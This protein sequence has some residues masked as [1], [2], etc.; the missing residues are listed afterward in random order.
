MLENKF[1]LESTVEYKKDAGENLN[2][3]MVVTRKVHFQASGHDFSAFE[4]GRL[5]QHAPSV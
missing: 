4:K 1:K 3:T 2:P 5:K